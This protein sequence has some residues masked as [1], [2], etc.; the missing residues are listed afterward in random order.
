MNGENPAAAAVYAAFAQAESLVETAPDDAREVLLSAM[1][2]AQAIDLPSGQGKASE[3]L[4]RIAQNTAQEELAEKTFALSIEK[5]QEEGDAIGAARAAAHLR[6]LRSPRSFADERQ[7]VAAELSFVEALLGEYRRGPKKDPVPAL[8]EE[9]LYLSLRR[10]TRS[11]PGG[12]SPAGQLQAA[13][14]LSD[15]QM[16]LLFA[17]AAPALSEP[18]ARALRQAQGDVVAR[19][20]SAWFLA[21]LVQPAFLTPVTSAL[22]H[23]GGTLR[24]NELVKVQPNPDRA[25][26][27]THLLIELDSDIAAFLEGERGLCQKSDGHAR[28][29]GPPEP[30]IGPPPQLASQYEKILAGLRGGVT[31]LLVSGAPGAGKK[32][33]AAHLAKSLGKRLLCVDVT[34]VGLDLS[35]L[36]EM[37]R[38]LCRDAILYRA[39]LA[40]DLKDGFES[41]SEGQNALSAAQ[42]AITQVLSG[43]DQPVFLIARH[44]E[45]VGP[46]LGEQAMEVRVPPIDFDEQTAHLRR[47]LSRLGAAAPDDTLL[48]S[49][50]CQAGL[51]PGVIEEAMARAVAWARL[52]NLDHPHPTA[53]QIRDAVR[54]QFSSTLAGI[55][56]RITATFSW[57]DL[58]LPQHILDRLHE[59]ASYV[60]YRA[61]VFDHWGFGKKVPYGRGVSALFAGPSGTG[62]TMAASVI[63]SELG[64]DLYRIDLSQI[65]SKWI[66]ET[67]KNLSRVFDRAAD[68]QAILLFDE[69]DALFSKRTEVKGSV[70]RYSNMEVNYLL[71]RL[72]SFDGITI[73]TT[74]FLT[75]I[76]EAFRRRLRFII[77]FPMPGPP[78]RAALWQSMLPQHA[79]I[80]GEIPFELL[81][82]FD[83]AGGNIKNAV[84]R[85]AF[86]AAARHDP[87]LPYDLIRAAV[88]EMESMGRLIHDIKSLYERLEI[89]AGERLP[90]M[91]SN[92]YE[93]AG[94]EED[95][96]D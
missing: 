96:L 46:I 8:Y 6:Y 25:H 93:D 58:I 78:E 67:E 29:Q 73:L 54:L 56:Q 94:D 84:M 44:S 89:P 33:L 87:I 4:G 85:A 31:R 40:L 45:L 68:G 69:A 66:G 91:L 42:R 9:R 48:R 35:R 10:R 59:I 90:Q 12:L 65:V 88:L 77:E 17:A 53:D 7:A 28:L 49:A 32:A 11:E 37:L 5:Y 52:R 15:A 71:Q 64:L 47:A 2:Q 72:E 51:T 16:A 41:G 86:S 43:H 60:R 95:D 39:Y 80:R 74:N 3:L 13:F 26:A 83:M 61:H 23:P 55:A 27:H 22:F 19:T 82:D 34:S 24:K 1:E 30:Y 70:D 62:K 18:L 36:S 50:A 21:E 79:E 92:L 38:L 81:A 57:E 14:Q 76:D 20:P 75:N 63:A